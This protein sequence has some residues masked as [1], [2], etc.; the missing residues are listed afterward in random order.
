MAREI[1][2]STN[3][4]ARLASAPSD[5]RSLT[6]RV[7]QADRRRRPPYSWQSAQ[8]APADD[9]AAEDSASRALVARAPSVRISARTRRSSNAHAARLGSALAHPQ[10]LGDLHGIKH[11]MAVLRHAEKHEAAEPSL[12]SGR[13][14]ACAASCASARRR[15]S[16]VLWERSAPEKLTNASKIMR[17]PESP[18]TVWLRTRSRYLVGIAAKWQHMFSPRAPEPELL[19]RVGP[20]DSRR[21]VFGV[22]RCYLHNLHAGDPC[23]WKAR[24]APRAKPRPLLATEERFADHQRRGVPPRTDDRPLLRQAAASRP[25][26]PSLVRNAQPR[27]SNC[28]RRPCHRSCPYHQGTYLQSSCC[29]SVSAALLLRPTR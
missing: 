19:F 17:T 8:E 6:V 15:R 4:R 2:P 24:R 5:H 9:S 18:M 14:M 21:K 11:A 20:T 7:V 29:C 13:A 1:V 27:I 25:P 12:P 23:A 22:A 3:S 16:Q 10:G 28:M 26:H